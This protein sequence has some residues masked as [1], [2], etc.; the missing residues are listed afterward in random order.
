M[1]RAVGST[2]LAAA[3]PQ[4]DGASNMAILELEGVRRSYDGTPEALRGVSLQVEP[5]DVLGLVGRSGAGKT[6]LLRVAAG[7]LKADT[8]TVTVF[9]LDPWQ[10]SVEVK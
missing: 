5:G 7:L 6:T 8:G 2:V 9:G 3:S 1:R 10:Q 4:K